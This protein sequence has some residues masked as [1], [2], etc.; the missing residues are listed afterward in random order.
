MAQAGKLIVIDGIDGSGKKTQSK[1]LMARLKKEKIPAETLNFP[2]YQNFFGQMVREYLDGKYGDPTQVEARLASLLYAADRWESAPKIK[3]WVA[4]G[5]LV[6]LDR[7][8]TSNLIHQGAKLDD[9]KLNEYIAWLEKLEF[10]IFKIPRPDLV[11]FLR[12]DALTSLNL[13]EKRGD[14]PDGHDT[15]EHL[16]KAEKRCLEMAERLNWKTVECFAAGYLLSIEDIG[17]RIWQKIQPVVK[18]I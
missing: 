2:Q 12:V 6:I 11:L 4:E 18:K 10:D 5:K 14:G 8:Y 16:Q 17:E 1:I 13:I 3:Q 7:Y 9:R 15:L